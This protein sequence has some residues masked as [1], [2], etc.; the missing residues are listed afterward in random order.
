M[1]PV[2]VLVFALVS[3]VGFAQHLAVESG[4]IIYTDRQG[5][6]HR[7]TDSGKDHEPALSADSSAV[8][9]VRAVRE[10]PGIG[11]PLVM[12]SELW[13]IEIDRP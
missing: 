2:R 4:N 10:V 11:V 9:F 13:I 5:Q 7:L 1:T 3:C 8:A 12:Q 6:A